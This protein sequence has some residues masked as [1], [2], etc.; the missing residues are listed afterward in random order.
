MTKAH[1]I[2]CPKYSA[3]CML[4]ECLSAGACREEAPS[5]PIDDTGQSITCCNS[6]GLCNRPDC[7]EAGY[8]RSGFINVLGQSPLPTT[9]GPA[10]IHTHAPAPAS[11]GWRECH[12]GWTPIGKIGTATIRLGRGSDLA[13]RYREKGA[14][15][16]GLVLDLT[17][18]GHIPPM[19]G[20]LARTNDEA[21]FLPNELRVAWGQLPTLEIAWPDFGVPDLPREWWDVL[22]SE[23]SR[24]EGDVLIYCVGGHGRTGTCA[25]ILSVLG[26]L[27]PASEPCPVAWL[28]R[29][30]CREVVES[31][32][33][34]DYIEL[35]TGIKPQA[36]A[37][38]FF[39][40]Y[41]QHEPREW[42]GALAS[43]PASAPIAPP[44]SLKRYKRLIKQEAKK[45][46]TLTPIRELEDGDELVWG[47][48]VYAWD[49]AER[50]W[51]PIE[52]ETPPEP[53]PPSP[54]AVKNIPTPAADLAAAPLLS[55]DEYRR[56]YGEDPGSFDPGQ[57]IDH[58]G[59][60]YAWDTQAALFRP[61][62]RTFCADH[63]TLA[64]AREVYGAD[65]VDKM[66]PGASVRYFNSIFTRTSA[67]FDKVR[68]AAQSYAAQ[69][70]WAKAQGLGLLPPDAA[71][72]TLPSGYIARTDTGFC[73][74]W[75][76]I[77]R[78]FLYV[79]TTL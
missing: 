18:R 69:L 70:P 59:L 17:D 38:D 20:F 78:L 67:G 34:L 71:P 65:T 22:V 42:T 6:S 48:W 53:P 27:L 3:D 23:I 75:N 73:Y 35:I 15:P 2:R 10:T 33:Q 50:R 19:G 12:S 37:R 64:Q 79:G 56:T 29:I 36:S 41:S 76:A 66:P 44:L 25:S 61:L 54:P 7:G 45:G 26:G 13:D 24:I 40:A 68:D 63:L 1:S 55:S 46:N 16:I 21:G 72:E 51:V 4:R 52:L 77:M 47:D 58:N 5:G 43:T 60:R 9:Y 49:S 11:R 74:R 28:R 8:C 57:R 62:A 31:Q 30:Y 32:E 14:P 39:F